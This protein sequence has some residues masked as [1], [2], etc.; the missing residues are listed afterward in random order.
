[1][2]SHRARLHRQAIPLAM[3]EDDETRPRLDSMVACD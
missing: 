3:L 2:H 1:M